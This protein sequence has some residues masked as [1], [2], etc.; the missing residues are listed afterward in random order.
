MAERINHQ[1]RVKS[2]PVGMVS[3]ENF[4]S[5]EESVAEPKDGQFLVRNLYLSFDPTQRAW[6]AGPTYVPAIEPGEVMRAMA[7][8][9]VIESKHADYQPGEFVFG[10]WGW[11]DYCTSDGQGMLGV[12]K[13]PPGVP[14]AMAMSVLGIT[15][16]T[17]YFG[18][19]EVGNPVTGE[20]AVVS[21]AAGA[22]RGTPLA[23]VLPEGI[24]PLR[25]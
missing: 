7:V 14:I 25:R 1:W 19:L 10:G 16:L 22:G 9:Q 4:E 8:G 13:L 17:A 3:R 24:E 5:T 20:T 15:G 6:L 23:S 21:G 12:N 11:Q 2:R 18:M